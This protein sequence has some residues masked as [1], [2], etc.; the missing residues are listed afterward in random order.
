MSFVPFTALISSNQY[1]VCK[2]F[3][4]LI[5]QNPPNPFLSPEPSYLIALPMETVR[6]QGCEGRCKQKE[7]K[8]E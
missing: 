6:V 1:C 2:V 3:F 8:G 5:N 7:G 4:V